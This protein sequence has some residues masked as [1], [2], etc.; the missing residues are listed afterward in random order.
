[1]MV[2]RLSVATVWLFA[3]VGVTL[4]VIFT[5]F[6][7]RAEPVAILLGVIVLFAFLVQLI[8]SEKEGAVNRLMWSITG[9]LLICLL[10]L[11]IATGI[12]LI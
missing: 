1:M 3:A 11:L 10:G 7:S 12:T 2:K 6:G 8:L 4:V 5:P 9:A